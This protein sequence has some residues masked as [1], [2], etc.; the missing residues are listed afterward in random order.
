VEGRWSFRW[1]GRC[2]G[3]RVLRYRWLMVC[4]N[5]DTGMGMR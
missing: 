1:A 2:V 5:D 4:W 3:V